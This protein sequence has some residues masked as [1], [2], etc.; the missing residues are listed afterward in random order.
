MG[1]SS[2]YIENQQVIHN[3]EDKKIPRFLSNNI[4]ISSKHIIGRKKEL[5]EIWLHLSDNNPAVLVNGIGGIGK[6]A[7]AS[8]YL[9]GY[10]KNYHHLA[11]LTVSTSIRDAFVNNAV[12][13]NNLQISTEVNQLLQNQQPNQALAFVINT[14]SN[15][16]QTLVVIDNANDKKDIALYRQLFTRSKCHF[17]LT[18]RVKPEGWKTVSVDSLQIDL[19]ISLFKTHYGK[20]AI[21]GIPDQKIEDL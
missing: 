7:L 14:L 18:S 6:T 4:P 10:N 5:Q 11:W 17:L 3:Y 12:L 8:K 9:V 1:D 13:L 16:K 2:N 21:E 15:R 20:T 19:A